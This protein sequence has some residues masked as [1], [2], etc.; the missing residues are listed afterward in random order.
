MSVYEYIEIDDQG[1]P[2]DSGLFEEGKEPTDY[3]KSWGYQEHSGA[4]WVPKYD[5]STGQWVESLT[6]EEIQ[7][8]LNT[9]N[10]PSIE[11]QLQATQDA[12]LTLM[13]LWPGGGA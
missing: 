12:L 5:F 8:R 4:W 10:P 2:I 1:F 7:Q 11:E 13:N 9:P 6:D 3:V